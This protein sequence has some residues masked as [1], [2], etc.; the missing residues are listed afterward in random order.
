[1]GEGRT[2]F[3]PPSKAIEA[4]NQTHTHTRKP[5]CKGICVYS[6]LA[7]FFAYFPSIFMP[8]D[9]YVRAAASVA[10]VWLDVFLCCIFH[11]ASTLPGPA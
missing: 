10:S 4:K 3:D 8:P 5:F 7:A 9:L 1:M 6:F 2:I 11:I